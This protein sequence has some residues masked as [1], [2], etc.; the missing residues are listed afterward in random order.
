M[1]IWTDHT[2]V[3]ARYPV[4]GEQ[5]SIDLEVVDKARVCVRSSDKIMEAPMISQTNQD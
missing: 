5:R 1:R 2:D 4:P 3:E